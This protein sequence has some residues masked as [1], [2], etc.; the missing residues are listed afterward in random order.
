[1]ENRS[2]DEPR[3]TEGVAYHRAGPMMASDP[4]AYLPLPLR[5]PN[6]R[7]STLQTLLCRRYR[8]IRVLVADRCLS[9]VHLRRLAR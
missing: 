9:F 8:R 1:M 3:T 2:P 5:R 6:V 4:K 7:Y